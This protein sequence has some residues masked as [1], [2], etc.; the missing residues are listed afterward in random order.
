M[1]EEDIW[2]T[3]YRAYDEQ[4]ILLY[5]GISSSPLLRLTEHTRVARWA[6]YAVK[7]TFERFPARSAVEKAEREAIRTERP[8]FN[9]A[10]TEGVSRSFEYL[11]ERYARG[12]FVDWPPPTHLGPRSSAPDAPRKQESKPRKPR[13]QEPDLEG[14]VP[15]LTT[16]DAAELLEVPGETLKDWRNANT[17]PDYYLL[18]GHVVRYDREVIER[19]RAMKVAQ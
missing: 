1:I 13:P 8:I 10:H 11:Q 5:V 18:P 9:I 17:G 7:V 2:N 16:A 4:D 19:W 12:L 14:I 15:L 6:M 3:L